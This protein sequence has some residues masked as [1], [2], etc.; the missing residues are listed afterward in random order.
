MERRDTEVFYD[1]ECRLCRVSREWAKRHD[2]G[3]HL[4]FR[5]LNDPA[6]TASLPLGGE[7]LRAEMWVRLPDGTLASGFA[8]WQA[9]LLSL[10]RWCLLAAVLGRPPLR[11]LGP[12]VYRLVA[13]HRHLL[14]R[15]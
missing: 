11:W 12:P 6:A 4:S 5:D 7:Q 14:T 10:P 15:S 8:A 1:G 2:A 3:G 13:R 9:V